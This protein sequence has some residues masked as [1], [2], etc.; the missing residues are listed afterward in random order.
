MAYNISQSLKAEHE[1]LHAELAKA[2]QAG[3]PVGAAAKT[4]AKALHRHFIKVEATVI[5]ESWGSEHE[6]LIF[7]SG[8]NCH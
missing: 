6:K 1:E 7:Q 3:G 2:I 4:V 8:G 5:R